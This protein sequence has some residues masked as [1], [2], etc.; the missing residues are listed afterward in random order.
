M[1]DVNEVEL[2]FSKE[3]VVIVK[4][5]GTEIPVEGIKFVSCLLE[6]PGYETQL[7]VNEMYL[8]STKNVKETMEDGDILEYRA[9]ED[10]GELAFKYCEQNDNTCWLEPGTYSY[11]LA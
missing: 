9:Y 4:K 2:K 1:G 6:E 5:D 8:D 11:D 7:G 10:D 3:E